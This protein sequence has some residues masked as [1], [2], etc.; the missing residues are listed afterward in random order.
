MTDP[1]LP[2]DEYAFNPHAD[3]CPMHEATVIASVVDAV[4]TKL[5]KYNVK[6]V[7]TVTL[8]IGDLTQLGTEQMEFAYEVLTKDTVLE[9]SKLAVEPEHIVLSCK[10]CGYKGP[11]R[12]I[13]FGDSTEHNIPVLSCPQCGGEV[14]VVAGQACCVKNM[15]IETGDD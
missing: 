8:T 4:L 15:D 1:A 12:T 10:R 7:H 13:D 9:G 3:T 14:E 2:R 6:K 5:K 11:A